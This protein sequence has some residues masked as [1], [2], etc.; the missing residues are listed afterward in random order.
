MLCPHVDF[1]KDLVYLLVAHGRWEKLPCKL[2]SEQKLD[3]GVSPHNIM[4]YA[5]DVDTISK[6]L[7]N[8]VS[9]SQQYQEITKKQPLLYFSRRGVNSKRL[10]AGDQE[11]VGSGSCMLDCPS[12]CSNIPS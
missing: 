5:F 4:Y 1:S 7:V 3:E 2:R 12:T 10:A 11:I 8:I 6:D 9:V